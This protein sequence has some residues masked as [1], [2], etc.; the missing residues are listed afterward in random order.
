[1][2]SKA[3]QIA[4]AVYT[5]LTTPAMSAVPAARVF[6][7]LTDALS[8]GLFPAVAVTLGDER[9]PQQTMIGHKDRFVDIDI[10]VLAS[11]SNP[12]T[13]ADAAVV[14][15]FNRLFADRTLGGVAL[16][17][18]EGVTVRDDEGAA[19]NVASVRKTYTIHYRTGQDSIE[20]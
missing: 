8:T 16:D 14:E 3:E 9:E 12:Y 10:T 13:A 17:I 2:S 7:D 5:A 1:M 20:S 19:D 4:G 15:S 11:G 6:R 18:L